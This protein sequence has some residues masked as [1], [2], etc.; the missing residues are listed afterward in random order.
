MQRKELTLSTYYHS[1]RELSRNG[2]HC[3]HRKR[4]GETP[5]CDFTVRHIVESLEMQ[6]CMPGEVSDQTPL[7][8]PT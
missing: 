6:A 1:L 8:R 7:K 2:F 3:F 4:E 5:N